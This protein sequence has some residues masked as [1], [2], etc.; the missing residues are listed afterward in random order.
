MHRLWEYCDSLH[1]LVT[2]VLLLSVSFDGDLLQS[3]SFYGD[4]LLMVIMFGVFAPCGSTKFSKNVE[5]FAAPI[6]M[7]KVHTAVT[8]LLSTYL[9]N[10]KKQAGKRQNT[11]LAPPDIFCPFQKHTQWQAMIV[12]TKG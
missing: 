11:A 3:V 10:V 8:R 6:F 1:L 2:S 5:V 9:C 12:L 4:L 7:V